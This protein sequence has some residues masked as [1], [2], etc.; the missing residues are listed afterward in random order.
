[1]KKNDT[2]VA[3]YALGDAN[4]ADF[5]NKYFGWKVPHQISSFKQKHYYEK[6]FF[7]ELQ[8]L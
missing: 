8:H 5:L 3:N 6:L 7:Q 4:T 2:N 1:M